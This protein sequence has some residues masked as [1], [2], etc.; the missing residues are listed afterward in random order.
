VVSWLCILI[1]DFPFFLT[2]SSRIVALI[3]KAGHCRRRKI[4]C[5]PAVGDAQQRCQNCIR[6]KKECVFYPVDN[7]PQSDAGRRDSS[8]HGAGNTSASSSPTIHP[9]QLSDMH[10]GMPYPHLSI[11]PNQ[12]LGGPMM[13]RPRT[14]SFSPDSKGVSQIV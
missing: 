7:P 1:S 2:L 13:K 4:R 5:I 10:P 14:D 8:V 12:D 11:P 6:L 9:G 3:P